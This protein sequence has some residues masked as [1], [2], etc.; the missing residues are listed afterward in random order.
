MEN[1]TDLLHWDDVKLPDKLCEKAQTFRE[2]SMNAN[3]VT[4]TMKDGRRISNVIL[5]EGA[6]IAKIGSKLITRGEDLDF[7]PKD[8][9]DISSEV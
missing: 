9:E 6:W 8:V 4:L 5:A 1:M 2:S 7:D 3:R